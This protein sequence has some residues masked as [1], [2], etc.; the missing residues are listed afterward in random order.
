VAALGVAGARARLD[1]LVAEA[2]AAL[3][4]IGAK[5]DILRAAARFIAE[6]QS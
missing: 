1:A 2:D 6:R 5:A 4:P 3:A